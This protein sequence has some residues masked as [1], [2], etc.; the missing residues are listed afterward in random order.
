MSINA[1]RVVLEDSP[2]YH[3]CIREGYWHS[4]SLGS[5]Y[6]VLKKARNQ[7]RTL[8]EVNLEP[9]EPDNHFE[10]DLFTL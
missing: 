5:G 10:E 2:Y 3:E 6:V 4:Q 8:V 7:G 1:F 9:Q